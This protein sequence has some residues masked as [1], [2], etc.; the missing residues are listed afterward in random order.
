MIH[1]EDFFN[2]ARQTNKVTERF[3]DCNQGVRINLGLV[4]LFMNEINLIHFVFC[5]CYL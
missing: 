2:A 5:K 1:F 4:G 3:A